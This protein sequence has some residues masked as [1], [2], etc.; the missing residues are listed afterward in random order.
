MRKTVCIAFIIL[1][2]AVVLQFT[3]DSFGEAC[4]EKGALSGSSGSTLVFKY[5]L[6]IRSTKNF[7]DIM[8][9]NGE[10]FP[11]TQQNF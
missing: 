8:S 10:N 6:I 7:I 2:L 9:G 4:D 1:V 11:L 3:D 5:T